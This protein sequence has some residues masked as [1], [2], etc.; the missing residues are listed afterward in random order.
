LIAIDSDGVVAVETDSG[1]RRGLAAV[2]P[3]GVQVLGGQDSVADGPNGGLV[4]FD[5][6]LEVIWAEPV[7]GEFGSSSGLS[8]VVAADGS[9]WIVGMIPKPLP[10]LADAV[11]LFKVSADGATTTTVCLV[12]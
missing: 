5:R 6:A 1:Y 2:R 12:R 7:P 11:G 4:R 10:Q 8:S 9:G 3:G